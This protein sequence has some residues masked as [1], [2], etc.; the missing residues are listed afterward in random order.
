M[1]LDITMTPNISLKSLYRQPVMCLALGLGSGLAPKAPG[2]FGTLAAIPFYL[3]LSLLPMSAYV[4][5][6]VLAFIAG[7]YICQKAGDQ[8]GVSDHPAIVW[9]EFVGLWLTY[10]LVPATFLM[11]VL[12]FI[13]FRIF[14]I[15][16]PWPIGWV[17]QRVKG[18][19]GVMLDD[20]L[21]GIYAGAILYACYSIMQS[22]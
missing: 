14:D 19:L 6:L 17:D 2:T 15:I 21:A 8:L 22:S 3:L 4:V 7:V 9:D 12:G 16:K 13:L 18:G 1:R 10:L 20:I 5:V 11:V